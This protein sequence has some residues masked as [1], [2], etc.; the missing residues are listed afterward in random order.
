ML[1]AVIGA[2]VRGWTVAGEVARPDGAARPAADHP[3][4]PVLPLLRDTLVAAADEALCPLVVTD[5]QGR[6]LWRGERRTGPAAGCPVLAHHTWTG[7]VRPVHDPDTGEVVG[8]VDVGAPVRTVHPTT[9][10]LVA[11]VARLAEGHLA[12]QLALRDARLLAR[13]LLHLARLGGGPGALL[14]PSGRVLSAQPVGRLPGR[15]ALPASGGPVVLDGADEG[16][17]EPLTEG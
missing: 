16:A 13:D 6:V 7:A 17:L 15:I 1:V 9:R 12:A 4:T 3:L 14:A 10:A 11:A 8:A 5:V 2:S